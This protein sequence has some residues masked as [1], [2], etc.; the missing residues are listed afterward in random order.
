MSCDHEFVLYRQGEREGEYQGHRY[1]VT[2][3]FFYCDRCLIHQVVDADVR[4]PDGEPCEPEKAESKLERKRQ[5]VETNEGFRA[6][7]F[8]VADDVAALISTILDDSESTDRLRILVDVA[9]KII[10]M[11][12]STDLT[13][14]DD[15]DVLAAAQSAAIR[16]LRAHDKKDLAGP[17]GV[18]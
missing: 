17:R 15:L 9:K 11:G 14:D 18:R 16:K 12:H 1:V 2:Q 5:R 7:I 8:E 4:W 13:A 3:N 10:V 6:R